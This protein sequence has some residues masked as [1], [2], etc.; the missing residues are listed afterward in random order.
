ML[1]K[2]TA[3]IARIGDSGPE[4]CVF[5]HPSA[6]V[7]LPAGTLLVDEEPLDGCR[8]E[9]F[10]ETGLQGLRP[11]EQQTILDGYRAVVPF[12]L[13]SAAADE[14]W[15]FTRIHQWRLDSHASRR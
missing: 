1:T 10:E 5:D 6:G 7:Q 9:G 13:E 14:W 12:A 11:I 15:V 2:T 3:V 4:V 8:R